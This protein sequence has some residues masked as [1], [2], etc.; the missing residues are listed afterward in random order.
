[1]SRQKRIIAALGFA[2]GAVLLFYGLRIGTAPDNAVAPGATGNTPA[3]SGESFP[4][5]TTAK[6]DSKSNQP[7][8]ANAPGPGND[9]LPNHSSAA[10]MAKSAPVPPTPRSP[11]VET[12]NKATAPPRVRINALVDLL[13]F[14]RKRFGAFPTA[15]DNASVV[16]I[17]A[18]KNSKSLKLLPEGGAPLNAKG[19]LLDPWGS[20]YF[21]H[22]LASDHVEIRSAGVDRA[23]WTSDDVLTHA[24]RSH[25]DETLR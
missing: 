7:G 13:E 8:V 20:A 9:L 25:P 6:D 11:L 3:S 22:F 14:Y 19:E 17:L 21:F 1:M 16:R 24:P 2:A 23:L 18:G 5:S 10:P 15:E 4:R 12:L